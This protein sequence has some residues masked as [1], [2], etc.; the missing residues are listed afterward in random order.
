MVRLRFLV[1]SWTEM[2][3][4]N[5]DLGPQADSSAILHIRTLENWFINPKEKMKKKK[6]R[7]V[8]VFTAFSI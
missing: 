3:Y 7:P 5:Y 1:R 8:L 4:T 2:V 6:Y